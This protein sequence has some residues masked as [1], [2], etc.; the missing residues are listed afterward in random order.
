M[1]GGAA[2]PAHEI[3]APRAAAR[4]AQAIDRTKKLILSSGRSR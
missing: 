4:Q 1:T 2:N 3:G